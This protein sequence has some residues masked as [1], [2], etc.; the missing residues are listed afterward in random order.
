MYRD[1]RCLQKNVLFLFDSFSL[2]AATMQMTI[3]AASIAKTVT[4]STNITLICAADDVFIP[5]SADFFSEESLS[6]NQTVLRAQQ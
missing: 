3:A 4:I 2:T 6:R 1:S 5:A